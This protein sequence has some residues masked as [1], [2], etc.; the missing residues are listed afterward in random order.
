VRAFPVATPLT[1]TLLQLYRE[2]GLGRLQEVPVGRAQLMKPVFGTSSS[3][4]VLAVTER[5]G[6]WLKIVFDDAGREG[7]V[8]R[9]RSWDFVPWEEFLKGRSAKLL[10]GLRKP[11]H[12]LLAEP[13]DGAGILATLTPADRFRVVAIDGDWALILLGPDKTGW[14][15]WRDRDHRFLVSVGS[16]IEPQKR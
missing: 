8:R 4:I 1:A 6:D 12:H 15:R 7:W 16:R 3:A 5:R 10:P 11:L 13:V 14:L 2:P 9:E